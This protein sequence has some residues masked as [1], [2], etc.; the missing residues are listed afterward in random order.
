MLPTPR[1]YFIFSLLLKK[2]SGDPSSLSPPKELSFDSA[3]FRGNA[4]SL[5]NFLRLGTP[6]HGPEK[7]TGKF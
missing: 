5:P 7:M 2:S 1:K 3:W 6:A 4:K